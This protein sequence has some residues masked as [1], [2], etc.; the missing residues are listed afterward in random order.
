MYVSGHCLITGMN[1]QYLLFSL[2]VIYQVV[3]L[4]IG[5]DGLFA[6]FGRSIIHE[7]TFLPQECLAKPQG[8][9]HFSLYFL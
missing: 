2:T 1:P 6:C 4:G 5:G 9:K 3:T 8:S 7:R